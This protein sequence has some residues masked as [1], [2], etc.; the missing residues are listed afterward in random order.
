M[1]K[2]SNLRKRQARERELRNAKHARNLQSNAP[3]SSQTSG[4]IQTQIPTQPQLTPAIQSTTGQTWQT[5]AKRLLWRKRG[6]IVSFLLTLVLAAI[7]YDSLW[8]KIL[9]DSSQVAAKG[10]AASQFTFANQTVYPVKIDHLDVIP[11][12]FYS[13]GSTNTGLSFK[14]MTLR[15]MYADTE[16]SGKDFITIGV[17]DSM[18]FQ[19]QSKVAENSKMIV[20]IT[21]ELPLLKVKKTD[22]ALFEMAHDLNGNPMWIKKP[23]GRYTNY[24]TTSILLTGA[25]HL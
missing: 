20:K 18:G 2:S 21:Y 23:L 22:S 19:A 9:I 11:I 15:T 24:K 16:I 6:A 25:K 4:T 5:D 13:S 3:T 14:Y 12:D 17:D 10:F 7:G 1:S 8:P